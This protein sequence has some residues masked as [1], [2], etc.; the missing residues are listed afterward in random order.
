MLEYIDPREFR[1][2]E[3]RE[4]EVIAKLKRIC[5]Y[6]WR[7]APAYKK[8]FDEAGFTPSQLKT[9]ADME[10][11]PKVTRDDI[12]KMQRET[13]PFGGFLTVPPEKLKRI[14]VHPG[15]QYE[16]MTDADVEQTSRAIWKIGL[17]PG[18]IV[19]NTVAYHLVPAGLLIDGAL[20]A[21][22]IT[23]V[24]SGTGNT[25]LQ[26]QVMHDLKVTGV[27]AFPLFLMNIVKRAEEMGYDFKRDFNLKIALA[28]GASPVRTSLEQDYGIDLREIYVYLPVGIA[29]VEC[30]YKSGMHIQEDFVLEVVE[31]AT[32]KQVPVGETGEIVVTTLFNELMPRI[33]I[34]SGDLGFCTDEP[35]LCGR[36]SNRLVRIVGRVGEA[37]KVKGMFIHP[38]EVSDVLSNF[39]ALTN[40]QIIVDHVELKDRVSAKFEFKEE[41]ADKEEI[42]ESFK[43]DFQS[44]CRLKIERAEIVPAGTI[45]K[46]A[47]KVID[48]RKQIIL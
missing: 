41:L 42:I 28:V 4:A 29:C 34:G 25:E 2:V 16:T 31:P 6:A 1:S 35:C 20:I 24:P 7:N 9:M 36:T 8:L 18:D 37:V 38:A 17:R 15:P 40:I 11:I 10:K 27:I 26:V 19:I 3:E 22:G 5:D 12:V 32:G 39:P 14:Y 48:E 45:P 33:R 43:K 47:K 30:D 13:P 21:M 23:V 44:R 46:D